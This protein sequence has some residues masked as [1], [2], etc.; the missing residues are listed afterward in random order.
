MDLQKVVKTEEGFLIITDQEVIVVEELLRIK[1]SDLGLAVESPPTVAPKPAATPKP[2]PVEEPEEEE[3]EEEP[4]VE[5]EEEE[6][7]ETWSMEDLNAL[8]REG[9][10]ELI[11]DEELDVDPEEFKSTKKL[12]QAIA[13]E[14]GLDDEE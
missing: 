4:E 12:R 14:L 6:E 5:E 3:E 8:D 7:E 11:E 13:E 9:L 2:A 10:E 1:K